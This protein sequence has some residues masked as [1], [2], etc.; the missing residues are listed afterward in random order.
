M[1]LTVDSNVVVKWFITELLSDA[2]RVLLTPRIDLYAPDILLTDCANTIWKKFHKNEIPDPQPYFDELANLPDIVTLLPGTDLT[3]RAAWTAAE[4][5]HPVYDCLYLAC[6]E[7]TGSVLVTADRQFAQAATGKHFDV[8]P[9]GTRLAGDRI[10]AAAATPIISRDKVDEL[11]EAYQ[12]FA[13][14][15]QDVVD[16]TPAA[17]GGAT[18]G[19]ADG[20]ARSVDSPAYQRLLKLLDDLDDEERAD[21]LA[22]GWLEAGHLNGNWPG[23]LSQARAIAGTV[24]A[25]FLARYGHHWRTGCERL[26]ELAPPKHG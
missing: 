8:W 18:L 6:S 12:V 10:L 4:L 2:A 17:G 24:D 23:N 5:D 14:A 11:V 25:P 22:L 3:S 20:Q 26:K 1:K 7:A 16:E 9:L 21:V 13:V 19:S 15:K